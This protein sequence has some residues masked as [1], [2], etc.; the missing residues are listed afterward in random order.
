[1]P[2]SLDTC[3]MCNRMRY[4]WPGKFHSK[5]FADINYKSLPQKLFSVCSHGRKRNQQFSL[6]TN[7]QGWKIDNFITLWGSRWVRFAQLP[8]SIIWFYRICPQSHYSYMWQQKE[9]EAEVKNKKISD[10]TTSSLS[11]PIFLFPSQKN[12]RSGRNVQAHETWSH[13][14]LAMTH[15]GRSS[16]NTFLKK[17]FSLGFMRK[18]VF[19][20]L[21]NSALLHPAVYQPRPFLKIWC[22]KHDRV[23]LKHLRACMQSFGAHFMNIKKGSFKG[24]WCQRQ[25]NGPESRERRKISWKT[26]A[27]SAGSIRHL[28]LATVLHRCC[29]FVYNFWGN[30]CSKNSLPRGWTKSCLLRKTF[31][32]GNAGL[33]CSFPDDSSRR[34]FSLSVSADLWSW[35]EKG[36]TWAVEKRNGQARWWMACMTC[37][38]VD[39]DWT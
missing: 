18:F 13:P 8:N 29:C 39:G 28:Q 20:A 19:Y 36:R 17:Y 9:T 10:T 1:M 16:G 7:A 30:S 21:I 32:A 15:L 24:E 2:D 26:A 5:V 23:E 33:Y 4:K 12:S 14:P 25:L 27:I 3:F 35:D 6:H 37:C 38:L 34:F 11:L 31:S 22:C